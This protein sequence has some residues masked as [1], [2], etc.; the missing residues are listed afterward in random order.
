MNHQSLTPDSRLVLGIWFFATVGS[1]TAASRCTWAFSRDGGIPGSHIWRKV[2]D[3]FG[4]PVYSLLLSTVVMA[5]LG[6]IYLGSTAA[7]SAFTGGKPQA[8]HVLEPSADENIICAVAT[9]CLGCSYAFPVLCSL[10]RRRKM[11]QGA[12]WSLGKFGYAIVS[13]LTNNRLVLQ[14]D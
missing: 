13:T 14:S 9:I 2:D 3:R 6:L 7:F 1:L 4:L 8:I 12:A 11:V 10:L 5:L